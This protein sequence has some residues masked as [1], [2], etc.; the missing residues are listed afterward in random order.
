MAKRLACAFAPEFWQNIDGGNLA[1]FIGIGIFVARWD[2]ITKPDD[3]IA[4]LN[5][6][7]SVWL[8]CQTSFPKDRAF[9][10][11]KGVQDSIRHLTEI[12]YT[13]G[14]NMNLRDPASIG[15]GGLADFHRITE[16]Y[17]D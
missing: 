13:P 4:R 7:D 12:C 15:M 3:C 5:D 17:M 2:E 9:V 10:R 14:F 11:V 6:K 16:I 1:D 8:L